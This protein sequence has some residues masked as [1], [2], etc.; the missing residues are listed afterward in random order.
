M[1]EALGNELF[2]HWKRLHRE[3]LLTPVIGF[4]QWD[5]VTERFFFAANEGDHRSRDAFPFSL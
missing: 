2:A 3:M 4:T 1:G 5:K